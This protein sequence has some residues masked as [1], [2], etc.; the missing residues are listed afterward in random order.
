MSNSLQPHGLWPTRLLRPWDFPSK[1]TGVGWH[2]LLQE[3]FP[4][5]GLNLGFLH[6]RQMP[7]CL[8]HQGALRHSKKTNVNQ[9]KLQSLPPSM[10]STDKSL[11][12]SSTLALALAMS[13][14]RILSP[15]LTLRDWNS[16]E[17]FELGLTG[18]SW[19]L[20]KYYSTFCTNGRCCSLGNVTVQD[21]SL[22]HLLVSK[23]LPTSFEGALATHL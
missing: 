17:L 12:T 22:P 6:C 23:V 15:S 14:A 21:W 5:Q 8:S 18:Y 2:F 19:G 11:S 10:K 7:Y 20:L 9:D 3:V 16:W 4:T 13:P 1:N